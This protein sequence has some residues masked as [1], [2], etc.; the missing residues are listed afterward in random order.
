MA[1]RI[2]IVPRRSDVVGLGIGLTDLK[3]NAGQKNSIYDGQHQNVYVQES[4]D[5]RGAPVVNGLVYV[6]GPLNSTMT[7]NAVADDTTGGGDDV[8]AMAATN[9]GLAAYLKDR[10]HRAGIA[11][12]NN[13]ELAFAECNAAADLI[14]AD[15]EAGVT[16]N[17]ARINVHLAATVAQTDLTGASGNSKSFGSVEDIMRILSGEV[18]RLPALTIIENVAGQFRSLAER[19][20]FVAAQTPAMVTSQGQFYAS[21]DFLDAT[22]SGY[23]ARPV[24]VQTG[25]ANLS[26]ASGVLSRL[27]ANMTIL[28][29]SSFAY[30]AADVTAWKPRAVNANGVAIAATGIAPVLAVY[31]NDGTVL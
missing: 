2:Y 11:A 29:T 13:G 23:R 18:Y 12:A 28:N 5:A 6:S 15:V 3:P 7:A 25:A 22:D 27:K 31:L 21:G 1:N 9:F 17:L 10:V 8:T 4:L 19:A 14:T 26:L 16:L 30:A 20:V 24:L